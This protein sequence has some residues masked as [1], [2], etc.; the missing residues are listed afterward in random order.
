[1]MIP[2]TREVFNKLNLEDPTNGREDLWMQTIEIWKKNPLFGIGA[3]SLMAVYELSSHNVFLQ[4]LAEMGI[5]GAAAYV[6][7]LYFAF[8]DSYKSF[9]LILADDALS[10]DEKINYEASLYMQVVFIVYSV[11]GNPLYGI[12]FVLPYVFFVAQ[13]KSYS[14]Y[15]RKQ[16]QL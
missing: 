16:A 9:K 3:G 11:F 10:L 6:L 1:M 4:V 7:M 5:L 2:A 14:M 15:R 12:S 8:R 13:L